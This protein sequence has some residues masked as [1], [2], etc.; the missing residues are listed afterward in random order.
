MNPEVDACGRL[1]FHGD[2]AVELLMRGIDLTGVLIEETAE[3]SQ[4]NQA[5]REHDK[6][7][8]IIPPITAG[9]APESDTA[10][11]IATWFIPEEFRNIAVREQLLAMCERDAE[12]A[13][14]N[15]EM[16]MF[17]ARGLVP[18]LR[19]MFF[20]V[21]HCRRHGIVWGVG[22]GSSVAS[23]CLFL[24][25]VHKCDSLHHNLDITEFLR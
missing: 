11:R 13:R 16:D 4:Y 10:R 6:T 19:L 2:D 20:L 3:I 7:A 9:E 5:C 12:I 1:R 25:G 17:E 15:Q 22:R 21:D 8:A 23:Y 18:V 24:I 14:V